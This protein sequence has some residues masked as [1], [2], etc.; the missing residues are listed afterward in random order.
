[1]ASDNFRDNVEQELIKLNKEQVVQFAWL[2]AVR[3]LPFLGSEGNFNFWIKE[4]RQKHLFAI[5]YALDSAAAN[6]A[7]YAAYA[8]DDA[9]AAAYAA[10]ADA[11]DEDARAAASASAAAAAAASA[12]TNAAAKYNIDLKDIIIQNLNNIKSNGGWGDENPH[13]LYGNIWNNFQKTLEAENCAYWGR[14][15]QNIFSTGFELD[16]EALERHMSVPKEIRE[17]GATKVANY[18][19]ELEKGATRLNEARIIILGDKGSGKTCLA[20]RLPNPK[21]DMTTTEESTA[22][23]DTTI[24]ELKKDNINVRIWD[25]AGHTVTHA[26]HR[27]FLSERCLYIIVYHGRT[28]ERKRLNYWLDHIKNYGGDSEAIILVNKHDPHRVKI[29]IN[30]LKD[31][32]KI[33]GDHYFSIRDDSKDLESF[34]NVVADYIKNKPSWEKQLLP[35]SYYSVKEK[36]EDIF[37]KDD[38]EN[39]QEYITKEDFNKIAKANDIDNVDE[40]LKD[41]H[42]LGVSLWYDKMKEYDMLILNPEWISHGVYKIINWVSNNKKFDISLKDF[43]LVF[44][45]DLTRFPVEKHEFLF[46]FMKHYELAYETR[47]GKCLIIPHLLNE[48]RPAKLPYFQVGESLMLRY[49]AEQPLPP[50]TIS[51]FIV[52]HNQEIKN[53]NSDYK[54]WRYGV[55]LEDGKGSTAMVREDDRTI[56]VS[57]K[58]RTKTNY[59]SALRE[60]LNDIFNSYQSDKPEL[61]YRIE[62]LTSKAG[63][64][65]IWLSE[66]VIINHNQAKKLEFYESYSNQ[67]IPIKLIIENLNINLAGGTIITAGGNVDNSIHNN[68]YFYNCNIG[69]Q[70]SLNELAQLL[71]EGENEEEAIKLE[72]AAKALEQA[73]QLKTKEEV[74]KKGVLNRLK[75][76]VVDL[77]DENSKL[78]KTVKGIKHGVSIAHDIVKAYNNIAQWAA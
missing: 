64:E 36:L 11:A 45:N 57:V 54:V 72:N 3:A 35:K 23:V 70:G 17:Q 69:L 4:N 28:D 43:A 78:Y 74:K 56:S 33:A 73:E 21:A 61:Q 37:D 49:K 31:K 76:L 51:R 52:R 6:A 60:T 19:E 2:C 9:R 34:R 68:S 42:F 29:P 65:P 48:D 71:K 18:L 77:G 39:G 38:K 58:G 7:A 30:T 12:A 10:Y 20:R 14:L 32:Y 63:K 8:D 50:D 46:D 25:F 27:F 24:W 26:V 55:I 44:H 47:K 75:R 5:F 22:G 41:L 13:E 59:I 40:L 62:H 53:E 1:M 66:D 67:Y 16:K 15:Y